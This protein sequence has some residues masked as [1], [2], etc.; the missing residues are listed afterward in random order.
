MDIQ[1]AYKR[2]NLFL[3]VAGCYLLFFAWYGTISSAQFYGSLL[4]VFLIRFL[5]GL[6]KSQ[7]VQMKKERIAIMRQNKG[8]MPKLLFSNFVIPLIVATLSY[9]FLGRSFDQSCFVFLGFGLLLNTYCNFKIAPLHKTISDDSLS[10][11]F[12]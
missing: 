4:A 11:I 8:L 1:K 9:N 6:S 5:S 2:T 7:R 12:E 10:H 3:T